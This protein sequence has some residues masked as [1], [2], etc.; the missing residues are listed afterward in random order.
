MGFFERY[1]KNIMEEFALRV[2]SNSFDV[3]YSFY[4]HSQDTDNF[5]FISPD[6][7]AA[8]EITSVIPQNEIE[9]YV[10]EKHLSSGK[11]KL[12]ANKVL[13]AN[14]REDGSLYSYY[15]G[16]MTE[17]KGKILK[18]IADKQ[19]IAIRRSRETF[20]ETI[21][22]CICIQGGSLFDMYSFE[23]AFR[24]LDTY[25]FSNIFFITPSYFIRYNKECGFEEYP[26]ILN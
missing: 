19:D 10:Y 17:I 21:D 26:R 14:L 23:L 4:I 24:N 1:D 15:G 6:K 2:I 3:Q 16:S 18:A 5:D 20:I 12:N 8:L 11:T 22:L 13:E 7:K 9:A 25:I